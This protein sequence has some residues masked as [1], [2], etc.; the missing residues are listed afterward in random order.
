MANI[1]SEPLNWVNQM[2]GGTSRNEGWY[3]SPGLSRAL[4]AFCF[5]F[6]WDHPLLRLA[7]A[8][9]SSTVF[10]LRLKRLTI[11]LT[12]KPYSNLREKHSRC[13]SV[14]PAPSRYLDKSVVLAGSFALNVRLDWLSLLSI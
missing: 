5:S 14:S 4:L 9:C 2:R 8:I 1:F 7:S 11:A 3:H 13:R 6:I 12:L 10:R